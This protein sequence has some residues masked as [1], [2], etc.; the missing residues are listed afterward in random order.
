MDSERA[1]GEAAAMPAAP[2]V[3]MLPKL[4]KIKSKPTGTIVLSSSSLIAA[5]QSS[6]A[7][8]ILGIASEKATE[9]S[10]DAAKSA[11][12]TAATSLQID[13]RAWVGI[14]KIAVSDGS[15]PVSAGKPFFINVEFK[16]LGKTP[17]YNVVGHVRA[18]TSTTPDFW[19][20][21]SFGSRFG[22]IQPSG[23]TITSVS[24]FKN[25]DTGNLPRFCPRLW[26]S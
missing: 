23:S 20:H 11:A 12:D 18:T 2:A 22:L 25:L 13:Q 14:V 6:E 4:K 19:D 24:P 1:C 10:A 21:S 9:K 8:E 5:T 3:V 17:A 16:N 15:N 7:Q 26:I